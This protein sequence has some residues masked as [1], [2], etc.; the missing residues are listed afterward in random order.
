M[1]RKVYEPR[2]NKDEAV[3]IYQQAVHCATAQ[4]YAVYVQAYD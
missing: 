4:L 2:L 1:E 3:V